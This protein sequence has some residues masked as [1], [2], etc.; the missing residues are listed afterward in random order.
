MTWTRLQSLTLFMTTTDILRRFA[1]VVLTCLDIH[2]GL[3]P[4]EPQ[5]N[6]SK[7]MLWRPWQAD[8][9]RKLKLMQ[10]QA[11]E[12]VLQNHL[13]STAESRACPP[14]C[15]KQEDKLWNLGPNRD[16]TCW[17]SSTA[18]LTRDWGTRARSPIN[19][20]LRC[21]RPRSSTTQVGGQLPL[22]QNITPSSV[23]AP[24]SKARSP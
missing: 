16:L 14:I 9:R 6:C 10:A 5:G 7:S 24:S 2:K 15:M 4:H 19:A 18:E 12:K 8:S 23:L 17:G 20:A 22:W 3:H 21:R 1:E 13:L 11:N